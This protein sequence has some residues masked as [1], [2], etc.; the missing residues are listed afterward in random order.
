MYGLNHTRS[1]REYNDPGEIRK[2]T[3]ISRHTDI[4]ALL[5]AMK[6]CDSSQRQLEVLADQVTV[7]VSL[8]SLNLKHRPE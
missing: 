6:T 3:Q 4:V 5:C 7:L 1:N 2:T 8:I